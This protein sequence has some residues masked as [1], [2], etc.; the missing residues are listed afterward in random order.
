[1]NE[2]KAEKLSIARPTS[3]DYHTSNI[4]MLNIENKMLEMRRI[5]NQFMDVH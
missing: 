1:M 5:E 3:E 2:A 4:I